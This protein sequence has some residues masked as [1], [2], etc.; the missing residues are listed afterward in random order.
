MLVI[1]DFLKTI[2]NGNTV[3]DYIVCA[4]LLVAAL[5]AASFI[6]KRIHRIVAVLKMRFNGGIASDVLTGEEKLTPIIQYIPFFLVTYYLKDLPP[7]VDKIISSVGVVIITFCLVRFAA[8]VMKLVG[9]RYLNRRLEPVVLGAMNLFADVVLWIIAVLFVLSN[10]G[11]NINTL[12]AGMGIGGMAVALAAQ[13][14]LS[15]IFNYFTILFDKPFNVGDWVELGG[16]AGTVEKIGLK[17]TRIRA[18]NGEKIVIS[19][20]DMT[21]GMLKNYEDMTTRRNVTIIGVEYGTKSDL[22]KQVP[23]VLKRCV[24]GVEGVSLGRVNFATFADSSLNFELVYYV[25]AGSNTSL[26]M[27][28]VEQVNYNIIDA[29]TELNISFAFPSQTVYLAK[30]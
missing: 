5:M 4:L 14:L 27:E 17:G 19:N 21:K 29:F 12:I 9:N 8:G 3:L 11:F 6:R 25:S 22:L 18:F 26:Y 15:D 1:N 28:R 7:I 10:I 20:T 24:A 2:I 23:Q 16:H 30:D 13:T